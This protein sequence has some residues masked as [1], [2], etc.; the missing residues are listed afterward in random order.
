[1]KSNKGQTSG[2]P[3]FEPT[4]L[5]QHIQ[6]VPVRADKKVNRWQKFA[7]ILSRVIRSRFGLR[8]AELVDRYAE[9]KVANVEGEAKV[10]HAEAIERIGKAA[11][12]FAK[13][14]QIAK[15]DNSSQTSV[16]NSPNVLAGQARVDAAIADLAEVMAS[17]EEKGAIV[18]IHLADAN[19]D[20][21]KLSD[22]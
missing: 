3:E 11:V 12:D 8:S 20:L 17:L 4:S 7:S 2:C 18:E 14:G 9:A 22:H 6:L 1:M 16:V 10:R 13:A 21:P 19:P 15:R 5:I